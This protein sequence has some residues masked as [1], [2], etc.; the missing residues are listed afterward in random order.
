MSDK[1]LAREGERTRARLEALVMANA[2]S[3]CGARSNPADAWGVRIDGWPV[4]ER[5]RA[6]DGYGSYDDW[7]DEEVEPARWTKADQ[8]RV[9]IYLKTRQWKR[10]QARKGNF[11]EWR[12]RKADR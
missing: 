6:N 3:R 10:H 4:F 2:A 1:P 8:M 5:R 7:R 11:R 9:G 12:Y